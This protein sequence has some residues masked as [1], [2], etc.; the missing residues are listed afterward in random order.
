MEVSKNQNLTKNQRLDGPHKMHESAFNESISESEETRQ[1]VTCDFVTI[2]ESVR[3]ESVGYRTT[4]E[5]QAKQFFKEQRFEIDKK[6]RKTEPT[7]IPVE[8]RGETIYTQAAGGWEYAHTTM[9][10]ESLDDL[11]KLLTR[12][13][14]KPFH[15]IVRG[16]VK[17][18]SPDL[19]RR[20]HKKGGAIDYA[21]HHWM[22]VDVDGGDY[23]PETIRAALPAPFRNAR[24][25]WTPSGSAGVKPGF[26]AHLWFWSSRAVC[27]PSLKAWLK[28]SK[29]VDHALFTPSQPHYTS[30]AI[31]H[32]GITPPVIE[33]GGWLDGV[34][35]VDLPDCVV[36]LATYQEAK[37]QKEAE[38]R[39]RTSDRALNA[40]SD[41][42]K[43][44]QERA[45]KQEMEPWMRDD[46][47]PAW[48]HY[49]EGEDWVPSALRSI[50][51]GGPGSGTYWV[52]VKVAAALK[53]GGRSFDEFENWLGGGERQPAGDLEFTRRNEPWGAL[54]FRTRRVQVDSARTPGTKSST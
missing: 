53:G 12:L 36:D 43:K 16:R 10:V 44:N 15:K 33:A 54:E 19:I 45:K 40:S 5:Y 2:L 17:E 46:D 6:T 51:V 30:K 29:V 14:S 48:H 49:H 21:D 32:D 28:S 23:T 26:R 20:Q 4:H 1:K 9:E 31:F 3:L 27:D 24:C 25:F 18:G 35:E 52:V 34:P 41:A 7:R 13:H 37:A 47:D 39:Q 22:M 50:S 42:L 11:A 8:Y 38:W